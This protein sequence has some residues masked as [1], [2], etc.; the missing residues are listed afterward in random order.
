MTCQA[1]GEIILRKLERNNLCSLVTNP[2]HE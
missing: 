2:R 1:V